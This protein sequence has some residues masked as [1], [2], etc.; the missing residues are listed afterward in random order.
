MRASQASRMA[1]PAGR[2]PKHHRESQDYRRAMLASIDSRQSIGRGATARTPLP[3]WRRA[4]WY[5]KHFCRDKYGGEAN[6][7][8]I[9]DAVSII[10]T[11]R[12]PRHRRPLLLFGRRSVDFDYLAV[13]VSGQVALKPANF[14]QIGL[15]RAA[16]TSKSHHA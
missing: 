8:A 9:A 2:A 13:A 11:R 14:T 16:A 3:R 5:A 15:D 12:R 10:V 7:D 4:L 6:H 1:S